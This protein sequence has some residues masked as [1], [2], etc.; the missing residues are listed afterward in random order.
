MNLK[1]KVEPMDEWPTSKSPAIPAS[2]SKSTSEVDKHHTIS[3][4]RGSGEDNRPWTSTKVCSYDK[5][6]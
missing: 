6:K 1:T 2:A 3:E 4:T 5:Q